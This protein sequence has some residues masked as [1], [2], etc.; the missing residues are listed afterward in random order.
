MLA[1]AVLPIA[2]ATA[3]KGP[4]R[5]DGLSLHLELRGEDQRAVYEVDTEGNVVFRGG[6]DAILD[7]TTWAGTLTAIQCGTWVDLVH[8]TEWL[9]SPPTS[10]RDEEPVFDIDVANALVSRS[11]TVPRD[12]ERAT[13]MYDFLQQVASQRFDNNPETNPVPSIETLIKRRGR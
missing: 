6:R 9:S 5:T 13:V 10:S 8:W 3:P 11:F 2:C 1:S 4:D 12:D 7:H